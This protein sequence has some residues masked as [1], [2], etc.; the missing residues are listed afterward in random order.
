MAGLRFE[1]L[2]GRRVR[3]VDISVVEVAREREGGREGGCI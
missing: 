3:A 1:N 2:G